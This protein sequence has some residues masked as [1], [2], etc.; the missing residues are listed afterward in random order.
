[1]N[2]KFVTILCTVCA[3]FECRDLV[4]IVHVFVKIDMGFPKN[5]WISVRQRKLYSV[6]HVVVRSI[7]SFRR[8]TY[9]RVASM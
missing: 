1:M 2:L 5:W 7:V 9:F 4:T 6:K 8:A 3:I